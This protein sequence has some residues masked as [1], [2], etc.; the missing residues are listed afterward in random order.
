MARVSHYKITTER[1]TFFDWASDKREAK[2]R[3]AEICRKF[4]ETLGRTVIKISRIS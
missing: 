1:G 3:A 4:G 2:K